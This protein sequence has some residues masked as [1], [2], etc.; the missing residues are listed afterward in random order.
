MSSDFEIHFEGLDSLLENFDELEKAAEQTIKQ[1]VKDCIEDLGKVSAKLAPLLEGDLQ[2]SNN[3][4][5]KAIGNEIIGEIKFN[6]PYALRRHEEEYRPGRHMEYDSSGRPVGYI[7]DG[8][9]PLTRSKSSVDGMEPG[10]KYLE[11]PLKKYEGKYQK[12][13]ANAV[14]RL[15]E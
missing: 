11:R 10:R 8:R 4:Q 12:Y 3:V 1:A 9:G 13:V 15:L 7:I 6:S 2:A 14:R 5:D